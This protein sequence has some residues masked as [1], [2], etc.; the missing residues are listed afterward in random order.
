MRLDVRDTGYG[1]PRQDLENIFQKFSRG[2]NAMKY[3]TTGNGIGLYVVK[4]IVEKAGGKISIESELGKGTTV[5]ITLPR[6][7]A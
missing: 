4:S 3:K 7:R 6:M 2:S 1:I 5:S